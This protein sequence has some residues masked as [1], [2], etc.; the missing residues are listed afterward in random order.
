MDFPIVGRSLIIDDNYSDIENLIHIFNNEDIRYNYI[1]G[2][3][4]SLPSSALRGIRFIFLDIDLGTVSTTDKNKISKVI[5]ILKKTISDDNGPLIIAFWTKHSELINGVLEECKKININVYTHLSLDKESLKVADHQNL[6]NKIKAELGKYHVYAI[7]IQWEHLVY[8][9]SI[10]FI[11]YFLTLN[12]N[13]NFKEWTESTLSIFYR[14]FLS[15]ASSDEKNNPSNNE[16]MKV[17]IEKLNTI[18]IPLLNKMTINEFT[19]PRKIKI[20]QNKLSPKVSAKLFTKLYINE[21]ITNI[22]VI[23][24]GNIYRCKDQ[25]ILEM[26][27]DNFI[28]DK[29]KFDIQLCRLIITPSCDIAQGKVFKQKNKQNSGKSYYNILYGLIVSNNDQNIDNT[30]WQKDVNKKTENL[31]LCEPFWLDQQ[32]YVGCF[33]FQ[34][35]TFLSESKFPKAKIWFQFN[36]ALMSEI[37]SKMVKYYNRIG[38]LDLK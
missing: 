33:F 10:H 5:S 24:R 18:F 17:A 3:T 28:K 29:T 8:K 2:E 25:I 38:L 6:K 20:P 31:F 13:D 27:S 11:N 7:L 4:N 22:K 15:T 35:S 23:Q 12:K 30:I 16:I 1:N 14:L 19:L 21:L 36:E 9:S 32:K 34:L 37:S 26:L